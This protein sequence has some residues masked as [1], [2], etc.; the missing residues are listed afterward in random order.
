MVPIFYHVVK[1]HFYPTFESLVWL[2]FFSKFTSL[3]MF[4]YSYKFC[5][6]STS[7]RF[8]NV[9]ILR[10][11]I[12]KNLMKLPSAS[13]P[14]IETLLVS[15]FYF[16][17]VQLQLQQIKLKFCCCKRSNKSRKVCCSSC[18]IKKCPSNFCSCVPGWFSEM[19][20]NVWG[21]FLFQR[22]IETILNLCLLQFVFFLRVKQFYSHSLSWVLCPTASLTSV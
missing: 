14:G 9:D 3:R 15:N 7:S 22:L 1:S 16:F 6:F 5:S 18:N 13:F 19:S 2:F 8:V 17:W 20:E 11:K 4:L 12:W 10:V 21:A